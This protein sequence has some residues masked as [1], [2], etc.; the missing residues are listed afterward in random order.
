[1]YPQKTFNKKVFDE[2][3]YLYLRE[4]KHWGG[5][6]DIIREYAE[7]F[8]ELSILDVGAGYAWHL[9]NLLFIV[10]SSTRITKAIALDYSEN[11]L[12][13][14]AEFLGSIHLGD[15]PLTEYVEL[16]HGN[17]L[18]LHFDSNSFDVVLCLNNTLGNIP[19]KK[20]EDAAINRIKALKEINRVLRP[21]GYLILSVYN[22]D[23]LAGIDNYGDVFELDH[24]L[25]CIDN[26]D[27]VIRF[28]KTNTCYYSHWFRDQEIKSFLSDTRFGLIEMEH[29]KQR[30][31]VVVQKGGTNA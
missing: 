1:M 22:A 4:D 15:K 31:V 30:I 6:L 28:K 25:S 5:D 2:C 3:S 13:K 16:K 20:F 24:S 26:F 29:R 9:A 8:P 7:K 11:M 14:A 27:L 10:S 19:G 17:I 12:Q 21:G 23:K 18:S